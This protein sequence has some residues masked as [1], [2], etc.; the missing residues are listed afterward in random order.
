MYIKLYKVHQTITFY[1]CWQPFKFFCAKKNFRLLWL[2]FTTNL[3]Q[4]KCCLKFINAW[5][6]ANISFSYMKYLFFKLLN[7]LLLKAI[8]CPLWLRIAQVPSLEASHSPTMDNK[9]HNGK[10]KAWTHYIQLVKFF[11][12]I[13]RP[14]KGSL[15]LSNQSRVQLIERIPS[16]ISFNNIMQESISVELGW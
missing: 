1:F 13:F 8:G 15:C 11:L 3:R 10:Y 5:K 16:Q 2:V 7:F 12:S 9:N 14:Y 6:I 4:T